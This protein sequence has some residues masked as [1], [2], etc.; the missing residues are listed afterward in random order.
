M[1][2]ILIAGVETLFG[3]NL[4]VSL[5]GHQRVVGVSF[6]D[7]V[8][9]TAHC[10]ATQPAMIR[11]EL[12][13]H[14][15][16]R[17]VYCGPGAHG[18]W[19]AAVPTEHDAARLDG[20]LAALDGAPTPFTYVSSDA[21]FT[22]PWMFHAENSASYC[23]S[24]PARLLRGME[25]SV[26]SRRPDALLVRTHLFGWT[27]RGNG[28]VEQLL[29]QLEAQSPPAL[30]C[31]RHA[32]PLLA[33]DLVAVLQRAW[34]SGLTGTYHITGAERVNPILFARRLAHQFDKPFASL[35]GSESLS[36]RATGF[37]R[38]ETSLQ[39]RKI[40][41]ALGIGL[42]LLSEGME[43]FYRQHQD[44]ERKRIQSVARTTERNAA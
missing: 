2:T 13:R 9:A 27:P 10:G 25:A 20:W 38:G 14:A 7:E 17:V 4:A 43:R 11:A 36:D 28:W 35:Y 21:I 44:G 34:Q 33:T 16:D 26:T 5:S 42:P 31:V 30:D 1:E 41:R 40:R 12:A 23:D 8:H 24:P 32:S 19:N 22:G 39:T 37:G 29:A 3:A 18:G 6:Q 15:I